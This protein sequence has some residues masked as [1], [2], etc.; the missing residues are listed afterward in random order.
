M[1]G[2]NIEVGRWV[3]RWVGRSVGR[4]M[5]GI[6]KEYGRNSINCEKAKN[7]KIF[8]KYFM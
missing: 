8:Y 6:W 7:I 1:V 2:R 3:G 5:E 4:N